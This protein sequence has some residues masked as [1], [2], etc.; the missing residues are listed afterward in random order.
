MTSLVIESQSSPNIP[1][2]FEESRPLFGIVESPLPPQKSSS[3]KHNIL[4]TLKDSSTDDF[5]VNILN[6]NPSQSELKY[7]M[8][9]LESNNQKEVLAIRRTF[10]RKRAPLLSAISE[11]R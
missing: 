11:K 9:I 1:Q 2:M 3:S 5:F 7:L 6:S 8:E 10:D 4:K